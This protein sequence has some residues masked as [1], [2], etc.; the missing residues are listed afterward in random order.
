MVE[1]HGAGSE[2]ATSGVKLTSYFNIIV[3]PNIG[4]GHVAQ[5]REMHLLSL[6]LDMLRQGDLSG[7]GDLLAARFL[8]CHQSVLDQNWSAARRLELVPFDENTAASPA[9]ILQA[10]K[11]AALA[12]R[13]THGDQW[14]WGKGRGSRARF[15]GWNDGE[16]Q[17][18]GK[19][20]SKKGGKGK[21]KG[22]NQSYAKD[23]QKGN[24][25]DRKEKEKIP[26]T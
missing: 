15:G 3:K 23:G 6:A 2:D 14:G 5:K 1:L 11:H 18:D 26:E 17:P 10:R 13:V 22:K 16:W 19:G 9:V 7:V 21:N 25:F 20:K 24:G 8:A 12:N 4:G